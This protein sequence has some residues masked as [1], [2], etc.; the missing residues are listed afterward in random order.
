MFESF[1]PAKQAESTG[2]LGRGR[3]ARFGVR[4]VPAPSLWAR[5]KT[6]RE[7]N[8]SAVLVSGVHPFTSSKAGYEGGCDLDVARFSTALQRQVVRVLDRRVS[9][10]AI[11]SRVLPQARLLQETAPQRRVVTETLSQQQHPFPHGLEVFFGAPSF[12]RGR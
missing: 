2:E 3:G 10:V 9:R 8:F 7:D 1:E 4:G 11:W 5:P 6:D 12:T